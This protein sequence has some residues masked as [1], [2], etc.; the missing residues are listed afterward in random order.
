M[1]NV[2]R[3]T[4]PP[5]LPSSLQ[6]TSAY[7]VSFI[8]LGAHEEKLSVVGTSSYISFTS[9]Y[10]G[11]TPKPSLPTFIRKGRIFISSTV[12]PAPSV[13]TGSKLALYVR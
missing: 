3:C 6:P 5:S 7:S 12:D 9:V 10:D 8:A 2:Y 13:E 11:R 4:P 1:V